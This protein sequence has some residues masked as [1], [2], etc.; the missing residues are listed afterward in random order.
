MVPVT[1]AVLYFLTL[2]KRNTL[3]NCI[4]TYLYIHQYNSKCM[5]YAYAKCITCVYTNC[6]QAC[7]PFPVTFNTIFKFTF[8]LYAT[9]PF[10]L[11][12][13]IDDGGF[14]SSEA[15]NLKVP[16]IVDHTGIQSLFGYD[17]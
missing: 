1:F 13:L 11:L 2:F 7:F 3:T 9:R 15:N 17:I 10:L 14:V 8:C 12:T 5:E 4:C 16:T 6:K